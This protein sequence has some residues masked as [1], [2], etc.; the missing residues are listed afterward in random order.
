LNI[1]MDFGEVARSVDPDLSLF[2]H[3]YGKKVFTD[4]VLSKVGDNPFP[5]FGRLLMSD[6]EYTLESKEEKR[7][8]I[9]FQRALD[10]LAME[11]I[12]DDPQYAAEH[13]RLVE[14]AG[15]LDANKLV[16]QIY[17][18]QLAIL[19]LLLPPPAKDEG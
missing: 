12:F 6:G 19:D 16:Q 17:T 13:K 8:W 15:R 5:L 11:R 7:A 1:V 10:Y 4:P 9:A 2:F 3:N 18:D 14:Q